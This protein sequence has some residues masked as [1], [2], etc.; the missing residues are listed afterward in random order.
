M[1][2]LILAT[3]A[4]A[5]TVTQT[6]S[7]DHTYYEPDSSDCSDKTYEDRY[8]GLVHEFTVSGTD[9]VVFELDGV[10][11]DVAGD[12]DGC[13]G[14]IMEEITVEMDSATVDSETLVG[15]SSSCNSLGCGSTV[16][17]S[18]WTPGSTYTLIL[19]PG[20]HYLRF[21]H[22]GQLRNKDDY[23]YIDLVNA[24]YEYGSDWDSDGEL[25]PRVGGDDCDDRDEDIYPGAPET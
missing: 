11:I 23:L 19:T 6:L 3:L 14:V 2:W 1:L 24:D 7:A 20:T 12:R 15:L 25:D 18:S 8:V 5:G 13:G 9:N 10:D 4:P 21:R 22:Y 16:M 17:T